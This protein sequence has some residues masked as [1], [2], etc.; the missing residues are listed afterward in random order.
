MKKCRWNARGAVRS[1]RVPHTRWRGSDCGVK[2]CSG[3]D[4]FY[5]T[6]LRR[7]G[8]ELGATSVTL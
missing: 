5:M 7:C 1:R 8:G 4:I 2:E 3:T 6:L